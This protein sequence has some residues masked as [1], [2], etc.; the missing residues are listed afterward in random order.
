MN[1]EGAPRNAEFAGAA[2]ER[3]LVIGL[4][5][6]SR[7][8]DAAGWVAAERIRARACR[9]IRAVTDGRGGAGLIDLWS[10]ADTVFV[11]DAA[12][13]GDRA[14]KAHVFDGLKDEIPE[15]CSRCSSHAF[16]LSAAVRLGRALGQLPRKLTVIGVEGKDFTAGGSLSPE[17]DCAV[18]ELVDCIL[19][20]C[21]AP[22]ST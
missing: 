3:V 17:V 5:N 9:G 16:G 14:G 7:G 22:G 12:S 4:G 8:D 13:S 11:I 6:P 18:S 20:E 2:E 21:G 1:L 19:R 10:C 15:A